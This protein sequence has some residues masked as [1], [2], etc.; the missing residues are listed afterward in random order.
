MKWVL[1]FMG[2]VK[3]TT[4]YKGNQ[5]IIMAI[6]YTTKWLK[7]LLNLFTKKLL[8]DLVTSPIL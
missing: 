6:D 1:D 3:P 4:K 2:L 7:A 5:Y 8:L